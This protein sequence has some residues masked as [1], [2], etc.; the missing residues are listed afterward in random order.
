[1]IDI[2]VD[3][4]KW[5]IIFLIKKYQVGQLKMKPNVI[6]NYQKNYTNQLLE[7]LKN[8]KRS[9]LLETIFSWGGGGGWEGWADLADMQLIS[10]FNKGIRFLLFIIVF[11]VN[12][13]GLFLKR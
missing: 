2:N 13:H 7:Y 5:S 10:K 9:H 3:F 1:M 6:K 4:L 8:E 12:T 11:S